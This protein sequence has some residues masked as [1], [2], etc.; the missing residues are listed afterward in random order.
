MYLKK[1]AKR[2]P[3]VIKVSPQ[4]IKA[5][6]EVTQVSDLLIKFMIRVNLVPL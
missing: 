5:P 2:C 3:E 1:K 6:A 4:V